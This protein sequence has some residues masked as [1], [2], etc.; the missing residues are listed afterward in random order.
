MKQILVIEDD[1][2]L[3]RGLLDN[4][5]FEGHAVRHAKDAETGLRLHGE[6][7]PDLVLL[8]LM[9]PGMSGFDFLRRVQ[10]MRAR[11]PVI[12]LSAR[13][14]ET[15][16]VRALDLGAADYV[17]KPF[18]L[19]ELLARVRARLR[20]NRDGD[21]VADDAPWEFG[22]VCVDFARFR[23]TKNGREHLLSHHEVAMLKLF[24]A[25]EDAPLKRSEILAHAWG[26]DAYPT[27]RTV[28]NFVVKLRRKLEDDPVAPR[29]LLTVHGYGYRFVESPQ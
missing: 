13:D 27:E 9:L 21:D 5:R 25:R 12:V 2:A 18:A 28:D 22:D 29:R 24:R 3:A 1:A 7:A 6:V 23:L 26:E 17:R 15:D 10:S 4:L 20:E 14:A 8:D 11:P 19:A 16:I